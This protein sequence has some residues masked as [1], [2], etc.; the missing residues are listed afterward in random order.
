MCGMNCQFLSGEFINIQ[1]TRCYEALC[2]QPDIIQ[3]M[4]VEHINFLHVSQ[5]ASTGVSYT[6]KMWRNDPASL[7]LLKE[8]S[9]WSAALHLCPV[10]Q[11]S[12]KHQVTKL[13]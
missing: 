2:I 12:S 8:D 11:Y 9:G 7:I 5:C 3:P 13:E 1:C 4:M 6:E 10:H